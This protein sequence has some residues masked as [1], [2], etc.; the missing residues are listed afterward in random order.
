M[1]PARAA[2]LRNGTPLRGLM[3]RSPAG[4]ACSN[5]GIAVVEFALMLPV[6]M[7]LFY[8]V[9]EI[10][11]YVLITQ[12]AEK[13]AHTVA[14][15]TAQSATVTISGLDQ[16]MAATS[17]IMEPFAF[18]TN[19]RVF[20]TSLYRTQGQANAAVNW[21]YSGGGTLTGVTSSF[22]AVGDTP[23][24]PGTF[25]F[26]ERENVIVAEVYVQ[27]SPLISN[28]FFGTTTVYRRAFYKP[29]FGALITTPA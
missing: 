8:G 26:D 17:D 19:G 16:L 14:D 20:I 12:K 5:A 13:L 3:A 18:G 25:T 6:L 11:R 29:R 15:V 28:K 1:F 24:M 7:T 4:F 2:A 10:T 23:T 21:R 22:G 9:I 27:F